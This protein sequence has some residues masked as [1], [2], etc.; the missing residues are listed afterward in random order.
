MDHI[1][2]SVCIFPVGSL[3]KNGGVLVYCIQEIRLGAEAVG[4]GRGALVVLGGLSFMV[5]KKPTT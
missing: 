1:R 4:S 5:L 2:K 3:R